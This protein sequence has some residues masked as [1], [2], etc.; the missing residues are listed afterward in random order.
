MSTRTVRR[1]PG[2]GHGLKSWNF[3]TP[4]TGT[5]YGV[6]GHWK[7]RVRYIYGGKTTQVP[8]TKRAE[9]H[10]WARHW[11]KQPKWWAHTVL[12]YRP[13][14]TIQEV[15]AAGG[16]YVIWQ[17]RT[18]PLILSMVEVIYAIKI[19]R[20]VHNLQWNTRNRR[21]SRPGDISELKW[22]QQMLQGGLN[23]SRPVRSGGGGLKVGLAISGLFMLLMF[24][25]GMPAGDAV[26]S[27]W[28]SLAARPLTLLGWVM[29]LGGLL[30]TVAQSMVSK[31]RR[32]RR[33]G[34]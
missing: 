20:P 4:I 3:W 29:I 11:E 26:A 27:M 10:L 2:S 15:L 6:R 22:E 9:D 12:G 28:E 21:R 33:R 5:V 24:L 16:F 17:A 23:V 14:G 7:G 34:R 8:W 19:K 1:R 25:P 32:S 18:V 31:R 30:Y 13:N